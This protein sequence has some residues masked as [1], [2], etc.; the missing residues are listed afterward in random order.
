MKRVNRLQ[1]VALLALV[2]MLLVGLYGCGAL[3]GPPVPESVLA[4]NW[5]LATAN[6]SNLPTTILTFDSNGNLTNIAY[7]I[8]GA[9]VNQ[10]PLNTATVVNGEA[11]TVTGTLPNSGS[12][13]FQGTLN[14]FST[15]A[16]GNLI[17]T[18]SVTNIFSTTLPGV[19]A[20]LTRQQ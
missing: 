13:S 15:Q 18:I 9:T 12:L 6:A 8:G 5:I 4:G 2:P 7:E 17:A 1:K 19:P 3:P 11:V 20:T 14:E 16:T 10:T